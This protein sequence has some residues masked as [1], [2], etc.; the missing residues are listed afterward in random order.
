MQRIAASATSGGRGRR[1]GEGS[2]PSAVNVRVE[3]WFARSRFAF[4]WFVFREAQS[5][6]NAATGVGLA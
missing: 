4:P 1:A 6:A 5:S 3:D 2:T